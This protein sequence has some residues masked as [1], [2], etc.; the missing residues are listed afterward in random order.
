MAGRYGEAGVSLDAQEEMNRVAVEAAERLARELGSSLEGLGGYAAGLR[1]G[2]GFYS[3]HVDGVGT[4]TLVL[5][6]LGRLYVAGWDCV[7]MN[8]NDLAVAGYR[9]IALVDYV[10]MPGPRVEEFR[11][12][13]R[14]LV[15]AARETGAL[16]MG[17]ETAMLPGL[18]QGFDV[19][20][21]ALGARLYSPS[22]AR[23]GDALVGVA[24][25]GLHA[26]GYSLVRKV[27]EEHLGGDYRAVVDGVDLAE[28]LARPTRIYS[29]LVLEAYSR[30]L[31]VAAAHVTG[32]GW[33]KI[34][35]IIPEGAVA[36]LRAPEPPPVFRVIQ[37]LGGVDE[38]EMY[39]VFNMGV[40]LVLAAPRDRAGELIGLARRHG[41]E[42]WLL[43]EVREAPT[44]APRVRVETPSGRVVE[45]P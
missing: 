8:A 44:G 34:A 35:R 22:K 21:T 20:C 7:A 14:G 5:E 19:V 28:E 40:G 41:M 42:A 26:N 4:K 18:I 45:L 9:T 38:E 12:I 10:A 2:E 25:S 1:L 24:S 6:R 15:D 36:A 3:L 27:V 33:A 16:L 30:G 23:P 11:E 39:R 32:G 13:V 17:G 29:G 43:G 37:R 31:A